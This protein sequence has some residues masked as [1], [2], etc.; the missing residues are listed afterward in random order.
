MNARI[1]VLHRPYSP[2][3]ESFFLRIV[4]DIGQALEPTPTQLDSLERSYKSTGDFL[5]QCPE[6][7]G[8]LEEVYA[9]GSRALGTMT[10]PTNKTIGYDVDLVAR[11]N[12]NAFKIYSG[13]SG[14]I[15]LMNR[16]HSA[17]SR[18]ANQHGLVLRRWERCVTL[19]YS[20][21]MCADIAPVIDFPNRTAIYG[22]SHGLI[23]DRN[24]SS[25][26]P[27]N[28]RGFSK[29][30]NEIAAISPIFTHVGLE[31]LSEEI[32]KADLTPLPSVEVFER[33]VCRLIQV[34]KIHRDVTFSSSEMSSLSPSSIFITALVAKIYKVK[35]KIP[36]LNQ[37]DLLLDVIRSMPEA[38][39]K[40]FHSYNEVEWVMDNPTAPGDNLASSMNS[41]EKQQAFT[42]WHKK[43]VSDV[44]SLIN[45]VELRQGQ[46]KFFSLITS[47]FGDK[48]GAAVR[49]RAIDRQ[50]LDRQRKN[51]KN[52]TSAGLVIPISSR[53][54]TFFGA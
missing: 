12:A 54:H 41:S 43:L 32:R 8:Q 46:D 25:F 11:L 39:D 23:P 29:L 20:D 35:A 1:D 47:N 27:T 38:I 53:D 17:I 26:H 48:A 28:P 44:L 4:E 31:S 18:Y 9:Q 50:S 34:M 16:L 45:S 6:F 2:Q 37:V 3:S 7:Q 40:K 15:V 51:M 21:G 42:Q 49:N 22:E 36:H 19:N 30:F 13:D 10:R 14:A 33:P 24:L 5:V 52:V